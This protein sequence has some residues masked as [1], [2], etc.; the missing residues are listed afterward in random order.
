MKE[1]DE[2]T[3]KEGAV[4]GYIREDEALVEL[5]GKYYW[6]EP[7]LCAVVKNMFHLMRKVPGTAAILLEEDGRKIGISLA[8]T[9]V[10]TLTSR[11]VIDEWSLQYPA[12]Q[13]VMKEFVWVRPMLEYVAFKLMQ[14]GRWGSR[15]RC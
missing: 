12:L 13:E 10:T 4:K 6:F 5:T 3:T 8:T 9:L 11:H 15:R 7:M 2:E 1:R 14:E